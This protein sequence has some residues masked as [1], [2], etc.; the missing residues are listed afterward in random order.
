MHLSKLIIGN[1]RSIKELYLSFEKGKNIIVGKNN[2][3]KSNIIK[4]I[5]IVLGESS[6]TWHKSENI[7]ANDFFNGDTSKPIYIFCELKRDVDELL[8]YEEIYKCFGFKYHAYIT[9]WVKNEKGKPVP[10][11]APV[12]H[13]LDQS[14]FEKFIGC[15]D[16]VLNIGEDDEGV[17]NQYVNPKL[18]NQGTFEAVFEDK[19]SFAFGFRAYQ[20]ENGKFHKEIRFFFRNDENAEWVMAF[21]APVRNELLQS[22]IIHSF[23]DPSVLAP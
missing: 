7:T 9:E 14:C 11:K 23:R 2:A 6:P 8:N 22:A 12:L 21:S 1:Y 13:S 18:K 5:D 20:L 19:F 16:A 17:D 3:G 10:I 15:L 4:A